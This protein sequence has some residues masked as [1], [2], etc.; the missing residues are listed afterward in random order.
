[1]IGP[2]LIETADDTKCLMDL[3]ET[4]LSSGVDE[5]VD[6]GK[7]LFKIALDKTEDTISLIG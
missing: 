2:L 4:A 5:Y 7:K 6:R 3:A 1:M